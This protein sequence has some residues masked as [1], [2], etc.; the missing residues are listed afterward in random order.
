MATAEPVLVV[1]YVFEKAIGLN[2]AKIT[3]IHGVGTNTL[4]QKIWKAVSGHPHVKTY[5]EAQ[6]EKFGYGATEIVFR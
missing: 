2:Y 3:I 5:Y 4:K 1:S 6:K